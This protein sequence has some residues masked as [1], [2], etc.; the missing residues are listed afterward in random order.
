MTTILAGLSG[1]KTYIVGA[2]MLIAGIAQLL[3]VA[4]PAFDSQSAGDLLMQGLAIIFL[5]Q[6]I[7]NTI[8]KS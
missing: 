4:L 8:A 2:A 5:R 3:G 1:Y 7:T 6:G